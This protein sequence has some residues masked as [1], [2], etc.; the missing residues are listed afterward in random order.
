MNKVLQI[1][2]G[3]LLIL[4]LAYLSF[5]ELS[6]KMKD[7]LV[8]KNI[9]EVDKQLPVA[10][11]VVKASVPVVKE[12]VVSSTETKK[13]MTQKVV[14]KKVEKKKNEKTAKTSTDALASSKVKLPAIPAVPVV[15]SVPVAVKAEKQNIK[16]EGVQ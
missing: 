4:V 6:A 3:L 16:I 11:P 5:S 2:L 12:N 7:D 9:T 15:P 1:L 13:D 10:M 14:I 8:S